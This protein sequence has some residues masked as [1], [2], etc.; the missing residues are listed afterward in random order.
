[1]PQNSN[2]RDLTLEAFLREQYEQVLA[3][4]GESDL[5]DIH[6]LE[7]L[8]PRFIAEFSC[9]GLV[10]PQ[11]GPVREASHFVV[12]IML[13]SDYLRQVN[14]FEVLTWLE[15]AEIFHPN[16]MPPRLCPGRIHAGTSL[17]D[18]VYQCY[19]IITYQNVYMNEGNALNWDACQWARKNQ[20]RFPVDPRPLKWKRPAGDPAPLP[21]GA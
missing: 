19:E 17:V 20:S 6:P 5:L 16:I 1:M 3:L 21:R 12:G 7:G 8:P 2:V 18:I 14:P 11:G 9:R 15:P 13:P 10:S 4:A